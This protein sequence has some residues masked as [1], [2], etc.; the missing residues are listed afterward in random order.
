MFISNVQDLVPLCAVG[1]QRTPAHIGGVGIR[2]D[3]PWSFAQHI[4]RF[5]R[6][7][8]PELEV[9]NALGDFV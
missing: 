6:P 8:E 9:V 5:S 2:P 7:D 3:H 4:P 1:A